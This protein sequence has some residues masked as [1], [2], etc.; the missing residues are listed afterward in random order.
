MPRGPAGKLVAAAE[1]VYRPQQKGGGNAFAAAIRAQVDGQGVDIWP[2]NWP[3]W[4][5]FCRLSSQWRIGMNGPTGLDHNVL[6]SHLDRMHLSDEEWDEW[7]DDISTLERAALAA[8]D[9][10]D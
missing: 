7:F 4:R 1:A 2:E 8:L 6:F 5:L 10:K 3:A 9:E